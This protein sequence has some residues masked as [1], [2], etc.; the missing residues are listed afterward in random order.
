MV[1]TP[2]FSLIWNAQLLFLFQFTSATPR[3]LGDTEAETRVLRNV[4]LPIRHFSHCRSTV[5]Q[6][7]NTDH[8]GR[9]CLVNRG[10]T[11]R[12]DTSLPGRRSANCAPPPGTPGHGQQ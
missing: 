5:K 11:C 4:F 2:V 7:D 6:E 10:L 9:W 8:R 1:F 12:P 3:R